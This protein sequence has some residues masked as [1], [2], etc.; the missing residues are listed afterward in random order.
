MRHFS[1]LVHTIRG[2]S[3][4]GSS[5]PAEAMCRESTYAGMWKGSQMT[6]RWSTGSME[7]SWFPIRLQG[8]RTIKPLRRT[9]CRT[10]YR[11]RIPRVLYVHASHFR[12]IQSSVRFSWSRVAMED[13]ARE[14]NV[15]QGSWT[16]GYSQT[17]LIQAEDHCRI[18]DAW[19][20]WSHPIRT[21]EWR[22]SNAL[23]S[24]PTADYL[25]HSNK[26]KKYRKSV[27]GK[28]SPSSISSGY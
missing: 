17:L 21:P 9:A 8:W 23:K 11:G 16:R 6:A 3:T 4:R 2:S 27:I 10:T 15:T 26:P 13:H 19:A 18:W 14:L 12:R 25:P 1:R 24:F 22:P 5:N 28:Y 7:G 20:R